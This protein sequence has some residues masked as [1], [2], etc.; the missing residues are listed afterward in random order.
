MSDIDLDPIKALEER[1]AKAQE[2][3]RQVVADERIPKLTQQADDLEALA[4][5]E[6][7]HGSER[8]L[9]ID[10]RGWVPGRGAAT[11]VAALLPEAGDHKFKRFQQ[12]AARGE[13]LKSAERVDAQESLARSCVAYPNPKDNKDLYDATVAL[14]PGILGHVAKQIVDYVQGKAIEEGNAVGSE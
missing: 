6:V 5:L 4:D 13:K 2:R 11:L 9:R 14:A 8:I 3:R 12:V 7:E 10:L 1:I